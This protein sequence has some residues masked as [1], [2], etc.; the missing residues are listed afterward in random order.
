MTSN[1]PLYYVNFLHR[2]IQLYGYKKQFNVHTFWLLLCDDSYLQRRDVTPL[3]NMV[4][5]SAQLTQ[6]PFP[7][8]NL[9]ANNASAQTTPSPK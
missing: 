1:L 3:E 4:L 6:K 5:G 8:I 9:D 2:S 7:S